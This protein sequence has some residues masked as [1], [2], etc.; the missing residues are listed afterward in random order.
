MRFAIILACLALCSCDIAPPRDQ[1]SEAAQK[2]MEHHELRD[3]MHGPI[4]KAESANDP[5]I[6]HDKDQAQAIEDSGG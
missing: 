3:A 2:A 5:N 4:E 1:Q 6:Q